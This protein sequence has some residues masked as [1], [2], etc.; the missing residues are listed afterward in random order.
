MRQFFPLL[1]FFASLLFYPHAALAQDTS[2][3]SQVNATANTFRQGAPYLLPQTIF[4]GDPGR[5]VVPLGQTFSGLDPFAIDNLWMLNDSPDL[6][7]K[8]IELERRGGSSRLLIDFIP[9]ATGT[10]SLPP[11]DFYSL[12]LD[13]DNKTRISEAEPGE[14]NIPSITGLKV[15]VASILDPAQMNLSNPAPPLAAPGTSFLIYGSLVIVLFVLFFGI[16]VSFWG[17]HHFA[18]LW[19]RF[20]RRRLIWLM[21]KFLR[22]LR[23]ETDFE[24]ED[25]A[26]Y[27]LTILSGEFREFL[28]LFTKV[29]CYSLSAEEFLELSLGHDE[30]TASPVLRPA[31]L[32]GLFRSWDILR[33]SGRAMEMS[34]L[35]KAMS[36]AESFI[37]ALE[38]AE[39]EKP[40][41]KRMPLEGD[42]A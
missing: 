14:N 21:V 35:F 33:F 17:K 32:F 6:V 7:I 9:Y 13:I 11:L 28:S 10:I 20:R 31:F 38:K 19:E 23:Q 41:P 24:K 25:R 4:V 18:E 12:G 42:V 22:R 2:S 5:L 3:S 40:L 37:T 26:R 30:Q 29:N 16:G 1:F 15:Q 8:R 34:D 36:E 39:K 27:Y